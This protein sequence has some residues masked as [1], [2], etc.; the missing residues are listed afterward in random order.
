MTAAEV[1]AV[2]IGS[3][4]GYWII[5][6]V[7]STWG[8]KSKPQ[9]RADANASQDPTQPDSSSAKWNEVLGVPEAASPAE[10]RAAYRGLIS[11]YHPDKVASLGA[12]FGV[13]AEAKT[14]E[15]VAAYRDGM[16]RH[17]LSA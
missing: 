16:R 6:A 4:V 15:I 14:K 13:L 8:S 11:K 1:A 17:G 12:E 5:S 7:I 2:V 9:P 3:L 10:I